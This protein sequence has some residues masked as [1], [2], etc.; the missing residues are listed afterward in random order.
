MRRQIFTGFL[1][2]FLLV[3]T[4]CKAVGYDP[5]ADSKSNRSSIDP[6]LCEN[7]EFSET[8]S[9][10]DIY[11]KGIN[12]YYQFTKIGCVGFEAQ[13]ECVEEFVLKEHVNN[14]FYFVD[15]ENGCFDG[16]CIS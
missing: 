9:G 1:L 10:Y 15:C 7:A 3:L 4:G 11:N 5:I 6:V 13:D 12:Q 8:D 14:T 16:E 2:I